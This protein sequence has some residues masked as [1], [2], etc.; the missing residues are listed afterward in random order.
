MT[1]DAVTLRDSRH[2]GSVG[3][4]ALTVLEDITQRLEKVDTKRYDTSVI[5]EARGSSGC[6]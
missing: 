6:M 1:R 2:S 5:G 3:Q 4:Q